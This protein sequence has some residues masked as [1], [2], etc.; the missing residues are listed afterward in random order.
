MI[1]ISLTAED[2]LEPGAEYVLGLP[3]DTPEQRFLGFEC[4]GFESVTETSTANT[5]QRILR[6]VPAAAGTP[7]VRFVISEPGGRF[8][9]WIYRPTGG[10]HERPSPEL[11]AL[12]RELAPVDLAPAER[13]ERIVRHV[14]ARFTYGVRDIGLGDDTE[15]MPALACD[16]HKGTCVDTHSYAVAAFRAAGIEAGYVSGLFF[17][18]GATVSRPGHCW[19]AVRANGAPH[20]WDISHFL[21]YDLGPVRPV[22]NPKPG[23]RFALAV[24][25]DVVID[26]R[27]GPVE[28]TRLSGL[29]L[30]SGPN[31]GAKVVTRAEMLGAA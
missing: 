23:R 18:E 15:D 13:V 30:L 12:M 20:H 10:R 16:V 3:I 28:F 6:L 29:G 8:P 2:I 26:G 24:G 5:G 4:R 14:E 19:L 27:E 31:R 21:K 22:L 9:E 7:E 1:D 11:V 25:R 17:P